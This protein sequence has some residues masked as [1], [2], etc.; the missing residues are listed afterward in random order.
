MEFLFN[1]FEFYN[2]G[3]FFVMLFLEEEQYRCLY[4]SAF[5]L[6]AFVD[7]ER[8][9]KLTVGYRLMVYGTCATIEYM[10]L[11]DLKYRNLYV[12]LNLYYFYTLTFIFGISQTVFQMYNKDDK[13]TIKLTN[14]YHQMMF[15]F[16][17]LSDMIIASNYKIIGQ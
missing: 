4:T 2:L 6:V 15:I 16:I 5:L 1:L 8:I 10:L 11:D 12:F 7:N 14:L 13:L 3:F 17:M 9:S